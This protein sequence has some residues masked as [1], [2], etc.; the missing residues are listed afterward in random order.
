[1]NTPLLHIADITDI[2]PS[3]LFRAEINNHVYLLAYIDGEYFCT[4]DLCTHEDSSLYLGS[5]HG[6]C[7][8]CTLHGSRFNLKTGAPLN[9]PATESLKTYQVTRDGDSLLIN[10]TPQ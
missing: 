2:E 5:L 3:G 10:P 9:E 6:D 1:M 7:I 8:A 4:D